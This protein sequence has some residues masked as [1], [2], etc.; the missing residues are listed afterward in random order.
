MEE[1]NLYNWTEAGGWILYRLACGIGLRMVRWLSWVA[2]QG[3]LPM[4]TNLGTPINMAFCWP[5]L[6]K[7]WWEIWREAGAIPTATHNGNHHFLPCPPLPPRA[8]VQIDEFPKE[9]F[10]DERRDWS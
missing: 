10:E 8:A 5:M 3:F 9:L 7:H 4:H 2:K 1:F 6:E